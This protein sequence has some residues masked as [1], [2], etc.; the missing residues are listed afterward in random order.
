MRQY[1]QGLHTFKHMTFE[2]KENTDWMESD[3]TYQKNTTLI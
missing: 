1:Y 2:K 3:S